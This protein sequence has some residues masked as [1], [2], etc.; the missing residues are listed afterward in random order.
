MLVGSFVCLL[1]CSRSHP[2]LPHGP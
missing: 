1:A 2:I